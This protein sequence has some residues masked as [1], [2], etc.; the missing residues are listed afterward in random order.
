M[1]MGQLTTVLRSLY[2]V[3]AVSLSKVTG[4]PF[5]I[6]EI[7]DAIRAHSEA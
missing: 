7:M 1:N 6:V 2:L 4:K 5:K 3:P